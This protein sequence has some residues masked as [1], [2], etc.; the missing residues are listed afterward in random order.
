MNSTTVK[1]AILFFPFA[2]FCIYVYSTVVHGS[3]VFIFNLRWDKTT[4]NTCETRKCMME[5]SL[6]LVVCRYRNSRSS[7]F[8]DDDKYLY[9]GISHTGISSKCNMHTRYTTIR[10]V[11]KFLDVAKLP[12]IVSWTFS[13][14]GPTVSNCRCTRRTPGKT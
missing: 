9:N 13:R 7:L 11:I 6:L 12:E 3:F 1:N 10:Y 5:F 4:I 14:D 2:K 8:T